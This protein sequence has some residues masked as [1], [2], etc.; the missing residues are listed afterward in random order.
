MPKVVAV[1][2]DRVALALGLTGIQVVEPSTPAE[3]E[4]ILL[5][6]LESDT[7]LLIVQENFRGDF[8]E[9]F[10]TALLRHRG[11]PLVVYCPAFEEEDSEVDAYLASI[12][13]PAIGYE[14]RL[15]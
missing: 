7:Q 2:Q 11:T 4:E 14:I 15:E 9:R 1:A 12:L 10:Q 3:V 13:K 8:S 5:S 6:Q